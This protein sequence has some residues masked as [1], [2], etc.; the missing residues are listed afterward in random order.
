M[1]ATAREMPSDPGG[2][3]QACTKHGALGAQYAMWAPN[4]GAQE[5]LA[6]VSRWG[7]ID[8]QKVTG[9][10]GDKEHDR[11]ELPKEVGGRIRGSQRPWDHSEALE[12]L[13][14]TL[15]F[16]QKNC[17]TNPQSS[18]DDLLFVACRN[19]GV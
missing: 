8:Y 18:L 13:V 7:E 2:S 4:Q 10:A 11:T 12:M 14:E 6:R 1:Q 15:S 19:Q 5:I 16:G 17:V 9:K 3:T